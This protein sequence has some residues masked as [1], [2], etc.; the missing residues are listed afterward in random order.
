MPTR[1]D[2]HD[3]ERVIEATDL[4]ELIGEHLDVRPKGREHVCMCPF[5]DDSKPSLTIVTHR[6]RPFYHC[7]ACQAHGDA[8]SFMMEYHKMSFPEAL[9]TLAERAGIQLKESEATRVQNSRRADLLRATKA[10]AAWYRKHLLDEASGR[11][12]RAILARL[13][14]VAAVQSEGCL[15]LA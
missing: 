2:N 5:H 14:P 4:V 1:I 6:D 8:I 11:A 12:A 9:R 13:Q 10:A 3:R 7:F 15:G